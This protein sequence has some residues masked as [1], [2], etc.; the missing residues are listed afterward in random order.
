MRKK[1]LENTKVVT[2]KAPSAKLNFIHKPI[3]Y[4]NRTGDSDDN[5]E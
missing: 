5:K 3:I 2:R 1:I 4:D